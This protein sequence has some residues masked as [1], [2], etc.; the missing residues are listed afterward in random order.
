LRAERVMIGPHRANDHGRA[1]NDR[2]GAR[3]HAIV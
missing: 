1:L 2:P 3:S